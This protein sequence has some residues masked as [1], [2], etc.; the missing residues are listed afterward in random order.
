MQD[1]RIPIIPLKV[2]SAA[3]HKHSGFFFSFLPQFFLSPS[4]PVSAPG[5]SGFKPETQSWQQIWVFY[6][7]EKKRLQDFFFYLSQDWRSGGIAGK[8]SSATWRPA[9]SS[10][11]GSGPWP[12][13]AARWR[14]PSRRW[15]RWASA[16]ARRCCAASG[17]LASGR[18][19]PSCGL[20][21]APFY[22]DEE[23]KA[24]GQRTCLQ[25]LGVKA[26]HRLV[27]F[28][29]YQRSWFSELLSGNF[30]FFFLLNKFWIKRRT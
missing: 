8:L 21:D 10:P 27:C 4:P 24:G 30:Y 26:A 19:R 25:L 15:R 13:P 2:H 17:G 9:C 3:F 5:G 20:C 1:N 12:R 14:G 7:F 16:A 18:W 11:C 29:Y 22:L 6:F 28:R 23:V